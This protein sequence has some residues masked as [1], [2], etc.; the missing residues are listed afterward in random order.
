MDRA[1]L[2]GSAAVAVAAADTDMKPLSASSTF[3]APELHGT[4]GLLDLRTAA[5][6]TS[7]L[8]LRRIFCRS[9]SPRLRPQTLETRQLQQQLDFFFFF[10]SLAVDGGRRR[11][12]W[13]WA[14]GGV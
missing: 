14:R 8:R 10:F 3:S 11:R 12:R 9:S 4:E 7:P 13:W 2:S 1:G 5:L 6:G